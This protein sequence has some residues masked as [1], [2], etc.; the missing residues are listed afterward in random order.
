MLLTASRNVNVIMGNASMNRSIIARKFSNL[1]GGV[2]SLLSASGMCKA[3]RFVGCAVVCFQFA[4][5]RSDAQEAPDSPKSAWKAGVATVKITPDRRMPMAGYASRKE[6]AEGTEQDLFAKALA[7][8]DMRGNRLVF[9]TMDLIGVQD[10]LRKSVAKHLADKYQLPNQWLL[11]NA[12]HTHCG[13]AY[14]NPDAEDYF[15]WLEREISS[16]AGRAIESLEPAT[17]SYSTARC[18]F[19]MN[20]RTPSTEGYRNHPNPDG[21]VDHIVPVLR[22]ANARG[23]LRAVMFGYAC[24]NTTMGFLRWLGDYAGYAQEYFEQDHPGVTALFL[25]GCGGD[26]NP[27]PRSQLHYAKQHGRSLATAV[28]AALELG[29][30]APR[31]QT[32][33]TGD[34]RSAMETVNLEFA[35]PGR[36]DFAYPV[37]AVRLGDNL[38]M[39]AL[40]S[41][42]VIDYS[43]RLK[44]E[45]IA[46]G[47]ADVWIAGY[48]NVYDGYIPSRRVL[49][50]GGYEAQ[51]RPWRPSLEERIVAK[52]HELVG[53]IT[54]EELFSA[55]PVTEKKS[56][57]NGVEGPACDFDGNLYAVNFARQQTIGMITPKGQA[58]VFV[59]LPSKSVGNGI[60]FDQQGK[61]YVADYVEHNILEIDPKTKKVRVFAHNDR[62]NQPND[63]AIAFDG[64]LYASDPNWGAGSGQV[65]RIDRDGSTKLLAEAMGTTNGI[66]VSPD[67]KTLYVN[68]SVQRNIWAFDLTPERE[69]ANKR[70]VK[71]FEDFGFDGMRCDVDG[72]LYVTRHGKGTVVKLTPSGEVLREIGVLGASPTN[73]CFGGPDGRTAYVTEAA[74][75][76]IVQFRVDRPGYAWSKS[77][78][79]RP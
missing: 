19:A 8:E 73:I 32:V 63:I 9:V 70:L 35:T 2:T 57:T 6:P 61:M 76:R 44:R 17:L 55:T 26:Q 37:Q 71:K 34:L 58:S 7:I 51:S 75:Q 30:P 52:A 3:A 5:L 59:E 39:V 20:R 78:G 65:W 47:N 23:D 69:L 12:S 72:N 45:L 68:E 31:H 15:G 64:T 25:M 50:E 33:L 43:I 38:L 42:V 21:P 16:L 48:S 10:R 14:N 67:G 60:C 56:F 53:K 49:E 36:P 62:M 79:G 77:R 24:H 28:E 74:E 13:P 11:M 29:Q 46:Q 41:E 27:Y 4:L 40:A 22:V 1:L 54:S 66:E 18:G